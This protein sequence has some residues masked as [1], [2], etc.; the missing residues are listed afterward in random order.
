MVKRRSSERW[1]KVVVIE[2][3]SIE[4]WVSSSNLLSQAVMIPPEGPTD[5]LNTK[6]LRDWERK[7]EAVK[8]EMSVSFDSCKHKT[9][10]VLQ[11]TAARTSSRF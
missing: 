2:K 10:G 1:E 7:E 5:G 9:E 3:S 11:S 4:W 6:D 8:V